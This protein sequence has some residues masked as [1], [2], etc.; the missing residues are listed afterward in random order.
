[1][2]KTLGIFWLSLS[3][4]GGLIVMP[5]LPGHALAALVAAILAVIVYRNYSLPESKR[6]F[7]MMSLINSLIGFGLYWLPH[8][9]NGGFSGLGILILLVVIIPNGIVLSAI[10]KSELRELHVK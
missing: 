8:D 5:A 4:T 7:L 6:K 10:Y 2:Q 1:M 3:A 9:S